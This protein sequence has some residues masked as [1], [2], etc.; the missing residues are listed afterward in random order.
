[1][2]I[3]LSDFA[4]VAEVKD[5]AKRETTAICVR[6]RSRGILS[7]PATRFAK[8]DVVYAVCASAWRKGSQCV[9]GT[10]NK[11]DALT[12]FDVVP[13]HAQCRKRY[14]LGCNLQSFAI[15]SSSRGGAMLP[16]PLPSRTIAFERSMAA[17]S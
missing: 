14:G 9:L 6:C 10:G 12:T 8:V 3:G 16:M 1:L 17:A 2:A 4:D 5:L 11:Y 7:T 15:V 13:M